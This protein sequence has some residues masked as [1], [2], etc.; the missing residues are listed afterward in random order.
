MKNLLLISILVL[1]ISCHQNKKDTS[2]TQES[3]NQFQAET[4]PQ[5]IDS[6]IVRKDEPETDAAFQWE[7][8]QKLEK[9]NSVFGDRLP[10]YF[11]GGYIDKN[12][13]LV[14]NIKGDLNSGKEKILKIIDGENVHF[15]SK[16]FS[17]KELDGVMD[18]LN[19]FY[20]NPANKKMLDNFI[21]ASVKEIE[22]YVEVELFDIS[23][24]KQK[25]FR[26][27]VVDSEALR[28]KKGK[29]RMVNQ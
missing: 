5:K 13:G 8:N 18:K 2:L 26:Q 15:T 14:L 27:K 28:F 17:K 29:G 6:I 19:A 20:T 3:T 7:A 25:E 21:G 24:E 23:P 4:Q 16:K 11:G 1:V 12:G 9:L 22:N 10:D